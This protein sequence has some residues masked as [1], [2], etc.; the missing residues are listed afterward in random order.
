MLSTL[1]G[2]K[3]RQQRQITNLSLLCCVPANRQVSFHATTL[4]SND[5]AIDTP[6]IFSDVITN[7][8]DAYSNTTGYFTAPYSGTYFFI[9]TSGT[10]ALGTSA[11]F[12]LYVDSMPLT[13][14]EANNDAGFNALS[15]LHGVAH[16]DAGHRAWVRSDGEAYHTF[17]SFS[18]FLLSVDL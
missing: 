14:M 11:T 17:S 1:Q 15:T 18:G 9:A 12:D 6:L 8:G 4:S 5:P 13:R 16:L 10:F 3:H 2:T 7:Q